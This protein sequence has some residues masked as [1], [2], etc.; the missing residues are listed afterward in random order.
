MAAVLGAELYGPYRSIVGEDP[1]V[2]PVDGLQ[3]V[4]VIDA[5][6]APP[7]L[8]HKQERSPPPRRRVE[9]HATGSARHV[10]HLHRRYP[11]TAPRG[12]RPGRLGQHL[13]SARPVVV[14]CRPCTAIC[15][16]GSLDRVVDRR[17]EA[18]HLAR[19]RWSAALRRMALSYE[20]PGYGTPA[21]GERVER[22]ETMSRQRLTELRPDLRRR[23]RP[24]A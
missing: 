21:S 16:A 18:H 10:G 24:A 2:Q 3:Q 5:A 15:A 19:P 17:P 22:L 9:I 6:S 14:A 7:V 12:R 11:G 4:G 13:P 20:L 1:G 8:F 23:R